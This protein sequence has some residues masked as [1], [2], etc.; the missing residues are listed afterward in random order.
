MQL[1]SW[2]DLQEQHRGLSVL[3]RAGHA[4][5][6]PPAWVDHGFLV[7]ISAHPAPCTG[8]HLVAFGVGAWLGLFL[9]FYFVLMFIP[10]REVGL[11]CLI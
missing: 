7:D 4:V 10:A 2:P 3:A 8:R 9:L 11:D 6:V 5:P 1:F